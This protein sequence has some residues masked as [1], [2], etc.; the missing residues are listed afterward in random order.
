MSRIC[1]AWPEMPKLTANN[2]GRSRDILSQYFFYAMS[3]QQECKH[4]DNK[5]WLV[6]FQ[7]HVKFK[8]R[9]GDPEEFFKAEAEIVGDFVFLMIRTRSNKA[10]V[11]NRERVDSYD[12]DVVAKVRSSKDKKVR[13]RTPMAKALVHIQV[14][15]TN[16]LGPFFQPSKYR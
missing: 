6:P 15:D 12:L 4:V 7:I 10:D 2:F 3:S 13:F 9:S 11:L 14:T 1:E 5:S 16:D 8:I